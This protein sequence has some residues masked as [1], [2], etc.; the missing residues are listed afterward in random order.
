MQRRVCLAQAAFS[1]SYV[2]WYILVFFYRKMWQKSPSAL[3]VSHCSVSVNMYLQFVFAL[4]WF[5]DEKGQ[6]KTGTCTGVGGKKKRLT[7]WVHRWR[8]LLSMF[9]L[10]CFCQ[11][12]TNE[13]LTFAVNNFNGKIAGINCTTLYRNFPEL[14]IVPVQKTRAHFFSSLEAPNLKFRFWQT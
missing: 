3:E 13:T 5:R 6:S 4:L 14:L 10:S 12:M 9:I 7:D 2:H 8:V 11:N 1:S